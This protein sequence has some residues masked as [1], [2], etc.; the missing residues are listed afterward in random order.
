MRQ[1]KVYR[2]NNKQIITTQNEINNWIEIEKIDVHSIEMTNGVQYKNNLRSGFDEI[3]I[4]ITILY[5]K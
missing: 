3:E 1:I 5:S 2:T 4:F